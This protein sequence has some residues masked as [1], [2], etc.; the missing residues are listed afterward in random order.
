VQVRVVGGRHLGVAAQ[1]EIES[2]V[3]KR[4]ITFRLQ[5]L[6][7]G[8]VSPGSIWGRPGVNLH[9]LTL[10]RNCRTSS[11]S[12]GSASL[13]VRAVVVCRDSTLTVP[14]TT[15]AWPEGLLCS[16]LPA[17]YRC[18]FEPSFIELNGTL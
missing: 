15:P 9:R 1:I 18:A 7:P 16:A 4:Y 11:I 13:M 3:R 8:V 2:K 10:A 5:A 14:F 17:A 12:R 6:T